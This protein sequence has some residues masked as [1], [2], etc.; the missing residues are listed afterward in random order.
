[1]AG[2][3]PQHTHYDFEEP[4]PAGT[5]ANIRN[6]FTRHNI[7]TM[8]M[9]EYTRD[10]VLIFLKE[11]FVIFTLQDF[12]GLPTNLKV[13]L[14][15]VL[16]KH[17]TPVRKS[18][19]T[20][21][22]KA[23]MEARDRDD[24]DEEEKAACE[25]SVAAMPRPPSA[26]GTTTPRGT[27]I[28]LA[29]TP[30]PT[31]AERPGQKSEPLEVGNLPGGL[32]TMNLR[33]S[34]QMWRQSTAFTAA[35]QAPQGNTPTIF[36]REL[37]AEQKEQCVT[38]PKLSANLAKLFTDADKYSGAMEENFDLKLKFFFSR[39]RI[40]GIMDN[41]N[42]ASAFSMML[43]GEAME[44]HLERCHGLGLSF[45]EQ[46]STTRERFYTEERIFA[47]RREWDRLSLSTIIASNPDKTV[48]EKFNAL[49]A[50]LRRLQASL[51]LRKGDDNLRHALINS[52]MGVKAC[53][54]AR[55]RPSQNVQ[56]LISDFQSSIAEWQA[57]QDAGGTMLTSTN[58]TITPT[59][60]R[61]KE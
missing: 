8:N 38:F 28:P 4:L 39:C 7:R 5:P 22:G 46:A 59:G 14:R 35:L 20:W 26:E 45:E 53:A 61:V 12:N 42:M 6:D 56:S 44:Y 48:L 24:D 15:N 25:N 10:D 30:G 9:G 54:S 47:L 11:Q 27:A 23:I 16:M 1:M 37:T 49:V 40:A 60:A 3:S 51:P 57:E 50:K 31:R 55:T 29:P 36:V 33:P 17:G 19:G 13:G 52:T 32:R 41:S 18:K 34:R 21:V 2:P 43:N 58:A